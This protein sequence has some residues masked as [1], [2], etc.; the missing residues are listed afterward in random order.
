MLQ[1]LSALRQ[2][3]GVGVDLDDVAPVLVRQAEQGV[4]DVE[5]VLADDGHAALAE[6]FVVVQQTAG[7]GVLD[8]H[9]PEHLVVRLHGGEEVFKRVAADEVQLLPAEEL[10]GGDVVERAAYALYGYFHSLLYL[11]NPAPRWGKRDFVG[12]YFL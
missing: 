7:D 4:L 9:Q 8:G 5:L 12:V 1:K 11:K 3:H 6:Q 10:V 2:G